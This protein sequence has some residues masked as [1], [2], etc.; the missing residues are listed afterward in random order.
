MVETQPG[1]DTGSPPEDRSA[2]GRIDTRLKTVSSIIATLGA[3][4]AAVWGLVTW[5]CDLPLLARACSALA[6]VNDRPAGPVS[7]PKPN[8][9][10]LRAEVERQIAAAGIQRDPQLENVK[11]FVWRQPTVDDR[12]AQLT[13]AGLRAK[14]FTVTD[15]VTDLA[16]VAVDDK[17]PGKI[18][19]KSVAARKDLRE[20][21]RETI[22]RAAPEQPAKDVA[23]SGL[24]IPSDDADK[25]K[26]AG[27]IQ[28]DMF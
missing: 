17:S 16:N 24:D 18:W 7:I 2:L 28:V 14:G 9:D 19:I 22:L 25:V 3:I 23:V 6:P 8:N 27:E 21:V 20:I 15:L 4:C 11:L 26:R 13:A 5:G 1:G 10:A 12:I